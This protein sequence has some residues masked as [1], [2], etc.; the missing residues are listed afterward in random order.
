MTALDFFPSRS[1]INLL[2]LS[3]SLSPTLS[4][5]P[6]LS[7]SLSLSLSPTSSSVCLSVCL[8][9]W[10]IV[11][12]RISHKKGSSS[13]SDK[14]DL[15]TR[16]IPFDLSGEAEGEGG[17]ETWGASES[18]GGGRSEAAL[19]SLKAVVAKREAQVKHSMHSCTSLCV[20][21]K[22]DS[23]YRTPLCCTSF[24]RCTYLVCCAVLYCAS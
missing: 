18:D 11:C 6:S 9:G 10:L 24:L 21:L 7:S 3:P 4:L 19:Q 2:L 22:L 15:V 12:R 13:R 23:T 16:P 17:D 20:L 5:L 1:A 14:K 8:S